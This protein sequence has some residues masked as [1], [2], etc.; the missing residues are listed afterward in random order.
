MRNKLGGDKR[1]VHDYH[2]PGSFV[3]SR[4]SW[5]FK[6]NTYGQ[7]FRHTQHRNRHTSTHTYLPICREDVKDLD[8]PNRTICSPNRTTPLGRLPFH[9]LYLATLKNAFTFAKTY[10]TLRQPLGHKDEQGRA[11][12]WGSRGPNPLKVTWTSSECRKTSMIA[13]CPPWPPPK[14]HLGQMLLGPHSSSRMGS[15][16]VGEALKSFEEAYTLERFCFQI[17]ATEPNFLPYIYLIPGSK[18]PSIFMISS[19]NFWISHSRNKPKACCWQ[20][21]ETAAFP[22]WSVFENPSSQASLYPV[23][24]TLQMKE[25]EGRRGREG[26][27]GQEHAILI[28]AAMM[29][30]AFNWAAKQ[31]SKVLT[32]RNVLHKKPCLTTPAQA[33]TCEPQVTLMAVTPFANEVAP[34]PAPSAFHVRHLEPV[35]PCLLSISSRTT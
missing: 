35:S 22:P 6:P 23:D 5:P 34:N 18:A 9:T 2:K 13:Q 28:S 7:H 14:H 19:L 30:T 29:C 27:G 8:N 21:T 32:S 33:L 3:C 31:P 10:Q 4:L 24:F 16:L 11:H 17:N 15:E 12:L 20:V 25:R 1:I 26:R